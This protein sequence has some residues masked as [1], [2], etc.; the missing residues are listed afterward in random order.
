MKSFDSI[1]IP[2]GTN[3]GSSAVSSAE[4]EPPITER[5]SR[6]DDL[7]AQKAA[8]AK[9]NRQLREILAEKAY[10]V[11][12]K[13]LYGWAL[14]LFFQGWFSIIGIKVFSD[15][16]V[17]AVTTAVTLNVF[18]AFLGVIRGLFPAASRKDKS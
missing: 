6:G 3:V 16:V 14:F 5:I 17:L 8:D 4:D 7:N 2:S 1:S 9:S 13:S 10:R 18:A 15:K 11:V 12:K